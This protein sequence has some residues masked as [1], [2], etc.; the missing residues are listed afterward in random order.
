MALS[1]QQKSS[2]WLPWLRGSGLFVIVSLGLHWAVLQIP[3]GDEFAD[4]EITQEFPASEVPTETIDVVRLPAPEPEPELSPTPAPVAG[5]EQ[6]PRQVQPPPVIPQPQSLQP[7]NLQPQPAPLPEP[8]PEPTPEP[9][10]AS[11]PA[12]EPDP[13]PEPVPTPTPEPTPEPTPLTLDER[14]HTLAEYQPNNRAKSLA[15]ETNEFL[16]WYFSQDWDEFEV[17]PLPGAKDLAPLGL[18]YPLAQCLT[19]PPTDGQLVVIVN[20]DGSL[21]QE[22]QVLGSTGYDVLDD[23]ALA[24]AAQY[25]FP[26]NEGLDQPAPTVYWLPVAVDYAADTCTPSP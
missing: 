18:A 11:T 19:P 7:L 2:R 14:L 20:P 15:T 25:E 17:Q 26:M 12:P 23:K 1:Q 24:D 9:A 8:D 13:G 6:L 5:A 10:P 4:G 22:P 3:I 16:N 21:A